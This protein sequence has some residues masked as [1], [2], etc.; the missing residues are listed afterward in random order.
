MSDERLKALQRA[1][2]GE[3]TESLDGLN[4]Q[5][6]VAERAEIARR[7][8]LVARDLIADQIDGHSQALMNEAVEKVA[9]NEDGC[10]MS[11]MRAASI[12]YTAKFVRGEQP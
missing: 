2:T 9:A 8:A 4:R 3:L 6:P 5:V 11:V 1:L 12:G 10:F 7:L